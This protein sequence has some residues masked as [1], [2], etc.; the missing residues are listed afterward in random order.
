MVL[1][2]R[3]DQAYEPLDQRFRPVEAGD[4]PATRR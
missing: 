2:G 4:E 1:Q 3:L